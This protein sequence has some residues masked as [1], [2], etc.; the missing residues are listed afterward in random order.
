MS[1]NFLSE[2]DPAEVAVLTFDFSQ[3]LDAGETLT[4]IDSVTVEVSRGVDAS[5]ASILSGVAA[6]AISG[7]A[8]T[9]PVQGGIDGVNYNIKVVADTSNASKRLALTATLPVR[10]Q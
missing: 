2:K 1:C 7:L 4:A 9:Q 5:S 6:I 3:A 8:V 10:S